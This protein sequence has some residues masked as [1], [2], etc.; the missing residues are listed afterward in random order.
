[1]SNYIASQ[2]D[3]D[4]NYVVSLVTRGNL[5]RGSLEDEGDHRVVSRHDLQQHCCHHLSILQQLLGFRT[6][7]GKPAVLLKRVPWLRVRFSFLAHR[8][9]P[10]PVPTIPQVLMGRL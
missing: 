10:L 7:T 2:Y 9:I 4:A 5:I 1:M 3:V 6:G 8:S